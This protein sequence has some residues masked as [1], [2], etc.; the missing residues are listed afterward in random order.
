MSHLIIKNENNRS[1]K[2][3]VDVG[4]VPIIDTNDPVFDYLT[5]ALDSMPML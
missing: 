3:A 1:E 2:D 5:E 4:D